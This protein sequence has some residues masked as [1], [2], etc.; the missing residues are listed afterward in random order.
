METEC[1][2]ELDANLKDLMI[3]M[4]MKLDEIG[5]DQEKLSKN[6]DSLVKSIEGGQSVAK[7]VMK[8]L[9]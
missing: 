5:R 2:K 3:R 7:K 4:E 1:G 9:R 6:I 8:A